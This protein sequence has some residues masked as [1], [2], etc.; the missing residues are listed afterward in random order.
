VTNLLPAPY[1][2]VY[3]VLLLGQSVPLTFAGAF[4]TLDRTR[5]FAPMSLPTTK[6]IKEKWRFEGGV[7]GLLGGYVFGGQYYVSGT[8]LA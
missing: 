7:G 2:I 4:L 8:R 3:A 6:Q 1:Q 5:Q